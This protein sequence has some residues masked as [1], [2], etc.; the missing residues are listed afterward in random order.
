MTA[1][2]GKGLS[3]LKELAKK[4]RMAAAPRP[5]SATAVKKAK[6]LMED[7]GNVVT[8]ITVHPNGS[9]SL[10]VGPAKQISAQSAAEQAWDEVLK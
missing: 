2:T 6:K 10:A 4:Q 7:G 5:L 8:A 9:F 1:E 3:F